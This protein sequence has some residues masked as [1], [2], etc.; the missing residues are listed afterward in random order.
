M[1]NLFFFNFTKK[2]IIYI[3]YIIFI[4]YLFIYFIIFIKKSGYYSDLSQFTIDVKIDL[5]NNMKKLK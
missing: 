4:L 2:F 5:S 1:Q 3:Y